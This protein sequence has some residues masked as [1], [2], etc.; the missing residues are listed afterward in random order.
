MRYSP[1]QLL[2]LALALA[3]L[4]L[5]AASALA[6]GAT[7]PP[8]AAKGP[9]QLVQALEG[10]KLL[11]ELDA[12]K[13]RR[14]YFPKLP[15]GHKETMTRYQ[16]VMA[17][18][19]PGAK[20]GDLVD[21]E[22]FV[23]VMSR[24][25]VDFRDGKPGRGFCPSQITVHDAVPPDDGEVYGVRCGPAS[26]ENLEVNRV[27]YQARKRG[28]VTVAKTPVYVC[29]WLYPS[30]SGAK[31]DQYVSIPTTSSYNATFVMHYT[32]AAA[33]P[34]AADPPAAAVDEPGP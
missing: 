16:C 26:G 2:A 23:T 25:F 6:G 28:V 30:S 27:Y 29:F 19:V 8:I 31:G 11:G 34:P 22:C 14:V 15:W 5:S 1:R 32:P 20:A 18:E 17:T 10:R 13:V 12:D 3:P 7:P 33:A 4:L 24:P 9:F 21:A